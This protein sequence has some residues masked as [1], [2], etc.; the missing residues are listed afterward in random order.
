MLIIYPTGD[1][2]IQLL[3]AIAAYARSG[4][5]AMS[6]KTTTLEQCQDIIV[7]MM[8]D[9]VNNQLQWAKNTENHVMYIR[10]TFELWSEESPDEEDSIT[11][12][13]KAFY[14]DCDYFYAEVLDTYYVEICEWVSDAI[15]DNDWCMCFM[16]RMGSDIVLETGMDFRIY[17]WQRRTNSGEWVNEETSHLLNR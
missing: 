6:T 1:K 3:D 11:P 14:S 17:D 4:R 10:R 8:D 13:Q 7:S 5:H 16:R 2:A 9:A 12:V 15:E